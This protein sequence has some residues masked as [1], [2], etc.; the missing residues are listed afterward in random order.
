MKKAVVTLLG[1]ISHSKPEY[2]SIDGEVKK[3]FVDVKQEERAIYRFSDNLNLF[4]EKLKDKRYINTLALLIDI[5][6]DREIMPIA[7]EKA[8]EIQE[9]TLNFL[10]VNSLALDNTIII[11]ESDYEGIFQQISEL[12][13]ENKY[14]SFIIDLTHGFRHL[15]I[16]MIVNLIIASIKDIDKIEHI[17]FAKEIVPAKEYEIIDLLDYIGLAKLSF[18]LENFNENYTVGN[19]LLFKNE[20]YQD[21]VDSL[22]IISGHILANSLKRLIERDEN[23]INETINKLEKL[24]ND[25]KKIATFSAS[26]ENIIKHLRQIEIL[27]DEKDYIKLFKFSQMMKEREYLL[28]SITLLNESVGMYCAELLKEVV[29]N[30]SNKIDK[31]IKEEKFSLYKVAQQSKNL[32]KLKNRFTGH[33]L[34][35]TFP[36]DKILTQLKLEDNS[37]LKCLIIDIENLR[38]NLAHGNSSEKIENVKGVINSLILEYQKIIQVPN[39]INLEEKIKQIEK[40]TILTKD[41]KEKIVP[42]G[43]N[44]SKEKVDELKS[45][46]GNR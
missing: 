34:D 31:F 6:P 32:I 38:N 28:N 24:K 9:K 5:F 25:D 23:L 2:I 15:P 13:Q 20:K 33:Y 44:A 14:E 36:K 27:K 26:I 16:L 1:M 46:F 11:N 40:H 30:M 4:S 18:V 8:K 37:K 45:L 35:E 17:F 39:E 10:N 42:K 21:L 12:L 29:P 41:K 3:I 43:I 7:T 22:R 19:K